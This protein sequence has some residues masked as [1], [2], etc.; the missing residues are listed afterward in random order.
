M[1]YGSL[2]RYAELLAE[3]TTI[4][5]VEAHFDITQAILHL[6]TEFQAKFA[7]WHWLLQLS[8]VELERRCSR[9]KGWADV[10][11]GRVEK[12]IREMLMQGVR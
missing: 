1:V 10:M 7:L 5:E 12:K 6:P 11:A 4:S 2:A 9:S 8:S 3:R